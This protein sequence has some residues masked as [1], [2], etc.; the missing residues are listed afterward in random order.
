MRIR[1]LACWFAGSAVASAL[2]LPIMPGPFQPSLESLSGYQCPDWF[3][4]AKFGIWAHW[5]PQCEPE[6]GDWYARNMYIQGHRNYQTHTNQYGHPSEFGFKDVCNAWKAE[7]FDPDR[8]V[9]LYKKAGTQY[10]VAMANHH[11]NFDNWD[12]RYQPWNSVKIGPGKD[13]IGL[14]ERAARKAGLR[15]GVTVHA[16]R[17]WEWF[18]ASQ[19]SDTSGPKA[20]VP[21]DGNLTAADGKGK[22]WEGLDPQDLYAQRHPTSSD[23]INRYNPNRTRSP[24][25]NAAYAQKFYNRV[26]DLIDSYKPDL[27]YFDDGGLPL[28]G[29]DRQIGLSIVAHL[30]NTSIREHGGR[31]EAVMNTKRIDDAMRKCWVLDIERGV[32]GAVD[33]RPWQT[34]TCIGVWHYQRSVYEKHGYKT[35]TQVVHTLMDI[36]SKNG[37]LL[38]NI[39][40]RGNGTIDADEEAFLAGLGDWMAVNSE[41]VYGTRSWKIFGEGPAAVEQGEAGRHGGVKDTRGK[42]YTDG[43]FRFTT[44]AGALYATALAW[45]ASG[46][47]TVRTLA[48]GAPGLKGGITGV[49]LL[50]HAGMLPF[51]RSSQGLVVTLPAQRPCAH[52]F[53]L[54]ITGLDLSA[55]EPE[56]LAPISP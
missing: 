26:I 6:D 32:S 20:G 11:D 29:V 25:P 9:A 2:D 14:W 38:L 41:A 52:A 56:G 19:L 13:L 55:S 21:Y 39:P 7:Q 34:D 33:P 47:L 30:Y 45:P 5:G 22:W 50:G 10:F 44:K 18:E 40:V 46:V 27:L 28:G 49:E 3:R 12:S 35:V 37:N 23:V 51:E 1:L 4:D 53:V 42:P 15:F 36:V 24:T 16:A 17:A 31:N 54:K 43:D 8:L 48:D